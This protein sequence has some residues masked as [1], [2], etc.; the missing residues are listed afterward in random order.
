MNS[1]I[2]LRLDGEDG[3]VLVDPEMG[4]VCDI[5]PE[6]MPKLSGQASSGLSYEGVAEAYA[7]P[8]MPSIPSRKFYRH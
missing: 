8:A 3:F 6:D 4:T 2:V 5:A 1:L 7:V